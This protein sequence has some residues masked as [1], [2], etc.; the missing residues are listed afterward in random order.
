MSSADADAEDLFPQHCSIRPRVICRQPLAS[1]SSVVRQPDHICT[2]YGETKLWHSVWRS[3]TAW[4][5]GTARP[6]STQAGGVLR[7]GSVGGKCG[8]STCRF[9]ELVP[10]AATSSYLESRRC[11][12]GQCW[13]CLL[14]GAKLWLMAVFKSRSLTNSSAKKLTSSRGITIT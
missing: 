5:S 10:L 2:S 3:G 13:T 11:G 8:G 9:H 14:A 1:F 12:H 7:H 6:G 4:V